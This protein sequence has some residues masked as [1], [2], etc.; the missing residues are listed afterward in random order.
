MKSTMLRSINMWNQPKFTKMRIEWEIQKKCK[1]DGVCTTTFDEVASEKI[2][3][4]MGDFVDAY[5]A[6]Y[7]TRY[8]RYPQ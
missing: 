1:T 6:R 7:R 4:K 3:K 8:G 2:Y 5:C